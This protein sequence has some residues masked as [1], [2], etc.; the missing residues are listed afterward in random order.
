MDTTLTVTTIILAYYTYKLFKESQE[1]RKMAVQ[2]HIS[3]FLEPGE[4]D[5]SYKYLVVSNMG[6]GP[7]YDVKFLILEDIG[8]YDA[9]IKIS[10]RGL[11]IHG[12]KYCP[13]NFKQRFFITSMAVENEKKLNEVIK[14]RVQYKDIYKKRFEEDFII[15]FNEQAKSSIIYTDSYIGRI[16]QSLIEI[17]KVLE[18]RGFHNTKA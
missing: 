14:I 13:V 1:T 10:Y 7:A 3:I 16:S 12:L 8:D 4:T 17:K 5:I 2:P 6:Q 15:A 9:T 18:I 11:F